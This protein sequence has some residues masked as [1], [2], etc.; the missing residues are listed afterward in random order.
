AHSV[1]PERRSMSWDDAP[2]PYQSLDADACIVD[3]NA[4]WVEFSGYAPDEAIGRPYRDFVPE[5]YLH[6]FEETFR[7]FAED[8]ELSGRDCYFLRKDGAIRRVLIFGRMI[9]TAE[10]VVSHCMVVDVTASR[11]IEQELVDS[12]TRYRSLFELAPNPIVVHDGREIVIA[13]DAAASFLGYANASELAGVKV[14]GLVHPDSQ[15]LVAERVGRMMTEDWVAPLTVEKFIRKD[16]SA[17]YGETIAS[18]VTVGGRRMIHVAAID[19]TK[20]RAA[21]KALE[22]SEDRFRQLFDA[23]PDGVVVHDGASVRFAN[24]AALAYFGLPE[25]FEIGGSKIA[26]FI[27]PDSLPEVVRRLDQ[28]REGAAAMPP[29]EIRLFRRDH[30]LW[31]AEASS[32]IVVLGGERLVQTTFRY[33]SERRRF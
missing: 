12:E 6:V 22:E 2:L 31:E 20:R 21:E 24:P 17:V 32:T 5:Q 8:G 26:D 30:S 23:A 15:P 4:P 28:L 19:L 7:I 29:L 3:V 11:E 10:G 1:V 13:N 16:G 27:H 9:E 18:P 14:E 25:G 33:L